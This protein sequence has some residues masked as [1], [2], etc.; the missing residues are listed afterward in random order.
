MKKGSTILTFQP[1]SLSVPQRIT[2]SLLLNETRGRLG[3]GHIGLKYD[4]FRF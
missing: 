3:V 4:G 2:K 1:Y